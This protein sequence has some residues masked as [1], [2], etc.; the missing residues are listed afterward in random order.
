MRDTAVTA[1][2]LHADDTAPVLIRHTKRTGVL[3]WAR[4]IP[5]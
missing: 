3:G 4:A 1:A 5:T 2:E